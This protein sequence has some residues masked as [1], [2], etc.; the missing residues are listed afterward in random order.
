[1]EL[2][3]FE[4]EYFGNKIVFEIG[5]FATQAT[6]AVTVRMGETVVMATVVMSKKARDR[7][8]DF[9]PLMVDYEERYYAAGRIKGPRFS[10]R[11][12]RPPAEAILTGRMIDRGLRPLFPQNLRNEIQVICYPLCIDGQNKPDVASMIAACAALHISKVPFDGPIA[13]VRIGMI[14]GDYVINPSAEEIEW[15]DLQLVTMGDGERVTM[16]DC[17][18][19]ELTDEEMELAMAEAMKA[20]APLTEFIDKMRK[21]I[22]DEKAKPE[23]L[24][25]STQLTPD[26]EKLMEEMKKMI[27]PHLDKYLFNNPKGSKGE[28]KE[29]LADLKEIIVQEMKPK[30]VKKGI[31][32][33]EAEDIIKDILSVFFYDFIEEQVTLAILDKDQ[34]VDGRKLDEIRPLHAEV[35]LLPRTHGSGFFTRGETHVLSVLTLGSPGDELSVENMEEDGKKRYYHHYYFPPYSVGE[36]KPLRGAGRREIGH[37]ALAEK[38]QLPILPDSDKFP[39]TIR[40]VSEVMSSNGSSS[41]ASTTASTL[42]L[43]DAGVPV[44]RPVA[45]IAMGLASDGKR[46]KVLTDLQDM[47]DGSGGMDFKVCSTR[48]G[49]TAIQM[50]TKTRGLTKDIIKAAFPQTRKALGQLLDL[51]EG[52]IPEPRAELSE[53]A[54]RILSFMID[55]EK[56]GD[57][58]GPG[59][60][61][62]RGITDSL[63]VQID[64][65][66]DGKVVITSLESSN[67]EEARKIIKGIVKPVEVGEVFEAAEVVKIMNF[68]AFVKLTPN[69]DGL[70]HVSEIDHIRVPRVSDRLK[71]G[72]KV[73]VK[74][75]KIE[76]GKVKVSMKALIPKPPTE[77]SEKKGGRDRGHG[78]RDD[79]DGRRDRRK[80]D[81][82]RRS[83]D[84]K[85]RPSH[86]SK[87]HDSKRKEDAGEQ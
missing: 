73:K 8:M 42:A 15:S 44:K 37:G 61:I 7:G 87:D 80:G 79:R 53:H 5:R 59:G 29:I 70:L 12:G 41:M 50:D 54:P 19:N 28:R 27:I 22:G 60:K 52:T 56:I 25:W 69:T 21:E 13:G 55:P 11:E 35:S 1:M 83:S 40:V 23:D 78:R 2:K 17:D 46:W 49:I 26:E 76:R 30:L 57:V 65:E 62:I 32:E 85:P 10:K 48:E 68:G 84:R 81:R 31:D 71:E 9:F 16:I 3:E 64:I 67:A 51:I 18:A 82:D 66:D 75:I 33:L 4:M 6:S 20:M 72:D 58:I 74:V 43:M 86:D 45:G 14:N 77:Y 24:C 47:E 34:R 38:A 63:D 39:Y 36:T